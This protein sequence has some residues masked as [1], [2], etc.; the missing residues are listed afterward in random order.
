MNATSMKFQL[1]DPAPRRIPT[2]EK[3]REIASR[4]HQCSKW[5]RVQGFNVVAAVGGMHQA[6]VF[7]EYDELLCG[8]LEGVAEGFERTRM[9]GE[10]RYH[11]VVRFGVVVRWEA[12]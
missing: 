6:Y 1:V 5:L 10:S 8:K 11:F 9:L 3:R 7:I 2:A 4:V 12:A